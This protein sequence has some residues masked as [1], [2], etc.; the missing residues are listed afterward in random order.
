[1]MKVS[2]RAGGVIGHVIRMISDEIVSHIG[3]VQK[4][5]F[6]GV[7]LE[8]I[9]QQVFALP[10]GEK[11]DIL[12]NRERIM[13]ALKLLR[14]VL[15]L[16]KMADNRTGIWNLIPVI[17]QNY[18]RTLHAAIEL[19]RSH[20]ELEIRRTQEQRSRD[21]TGPCSGGD[22]RLTKRQQLGVYTRA[23]HTLEILES[24]ASQVG[25][26]IEAARKDNNVGVP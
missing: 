18:L 19:S 11:T 23:L 1:M 24:A 21:V 7:E 15:P 5:H 2:L 26:D 16:D 6:A 25:S 3:C 17:E 9:L 22:A 12:E 10:N 20:Y 13:A 14:V 8:R 4:N